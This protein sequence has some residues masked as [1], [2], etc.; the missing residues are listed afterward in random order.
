[1]FCFECSSICLFNGW[2]SGRVKRL[3]K[4]KSSCMQWALSCLSATINKHVVLSDN[5]EKAELAYLKNCPPRAQAILLYC[6]AYLDHFAQN[7]RPI[8][9]IISTN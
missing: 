5:L 4:V 8:H 7:C 3:K 1:M 6:S 2:E 9:V